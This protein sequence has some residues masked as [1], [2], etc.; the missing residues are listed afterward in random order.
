[1]KFG[2]FLVLNAVLICPTPAWSQM[3]SV[4]PKDTFAASRL[5]AKEIH[6]IVEAVAQSAYDTADSWQK[7]LRARRVD[8][9]ATQG[10]V[11]RGTNLLC[12]GTGNCQ[13]WIFRKVNDKWVPLFKGDEAPIVESFRLG[14]HVTAGIKDFAAFANFSAGA[15]QKVTYKFDGKFYRAK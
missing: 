7:E 4:G 9:G 15:G 2:A 13:T 11:V 8:L 6:E 5:S 12:G 10:L 1:M 3:Q 14:P